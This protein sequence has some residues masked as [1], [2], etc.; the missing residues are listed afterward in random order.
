MAI[1]IQVDKI[2]SGGVDLYVSG[3]L[4]ASGNYVTGGDT[5]DFTGVSS[6]LSMASDQSGPAN[7]ITS[8]FLKAFSAWSEGGLLSYQYAPVC[9][10][11]G[12]LSAAKLKV[13]A[14]NTFGTELSAG[15]YPAAVTG[16]TIK[17][18]ARFKKNN[19]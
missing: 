13:G 1:A 19:V 6:V 12:S 18:E 10:A 3:V 14:N 9:P 17:F 16:D 8:Q 15:A 5:V 7:Q 2:E 4:V 11:S